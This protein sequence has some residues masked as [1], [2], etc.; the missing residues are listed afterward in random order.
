MFALL[1]YRI[2]LLSL[3]PIVL[4][5]LL[6]RSKNNKQYRQRISER[7]GFISN[8]IKPD[9]IVVHAA[10][11]GEVLALKPFINELLTNYPALA[12][13]VTTFT[14]TGS[15]QVKKLFGNSVQH[16]YLPLDIFPCTWL[17][18]QRV[19]PQLVIFME[20]ELWPN[21]IAQCHHKKIKLLLING[22]LSKKSLHSYS[23]LK[24]L[25]TP[26][27]QRFDTILTQSQQNLAHFIQLGARSEQCLNSGNVKFD[28]SINDE[29]AQKQTELAQYIPNHRKTWIVASTHQGDEKLA[30]LAFTKILAH[31]P[32][33]LLVLVPRH[34]ERFQ[35]VAE[36]CQKQGFSTI[37]RSDKK[38]INDENI[39]LLDSLGE[40]MATFA[41]GDIITMGGSFSGSIGGHNPLEP[42][43]FKKPIIVGNDMSNFTEVMQQMQ[44]ENGIVQLKTPATTTSIDEQ[45]DELANSVIKLLSAPEQ[46]HILGQH[47]YN[48][49]LAN[50]GATQTTLQQVQSLL[51]Q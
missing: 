39:W 42:A 5:A 35:S 44:H 10:S 21:L 25:I 13:T 9:G 48:V 2:L 31:F 45:A 7:L 6:L 19:K 20:T 12:I 49:V 14:P 51:N 8:S 22:R 4:I 18:L 38:V 36:Q 29:L 26:C 43:L 23:K 15:A 37:K 28:I 50:Q 30:L 1:F 16:C 41:L 32:Q 11:V 17:F 24:A 47:A 27:L 34:P 40:L 33:L 3:L 46:Q